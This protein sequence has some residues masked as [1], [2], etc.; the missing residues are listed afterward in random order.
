MNFLSS[1][2]RKIFEAHIQI[3]GV[4]PFQWCLTGMHL[5]KRQHGEHMA[6]ICMPHKGVILSS[7]VS[8]RQDYAL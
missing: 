7:S 1:I 3:N 6:G 5:S 4:K 8:Q 2:K